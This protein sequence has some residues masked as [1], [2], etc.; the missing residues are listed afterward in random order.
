MRVQTE[1]R[2]ACG[3]P[4]AARGWRHGVLA[5]AAVV[6][7]LQ[8]APARALPGDPPYE[9]QLL[10]LAEILGG[11]HH[12]RPLCGSNEGQLWRDK[13]NALITAEEPSPER[14]R[15]IVE[16]FNTSYRSLAEI[17]RTCTPAAT[18]IIERYLSEGGKLTREIV[19]RYGRP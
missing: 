1:A 5:L 2:R 4:G 19:V 7:V 10:R 15:R 12:L 8:G 16:R 18:E 6:A 9:E 14:K 17:H 13:M 3:G 11:L